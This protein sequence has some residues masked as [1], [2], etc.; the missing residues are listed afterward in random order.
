M[1]WTGKRGESADRG[2]A[3]K[4]S[5]LKDDSTKETTF[6]Q[7]DIAK[8]LAKLDC[9]ES[10]IEQLKRETPKYITAQSSIDKQM[11]AVAKVIRHV[12]SLEVFISLREFNRPI[13]LLHI[14]K[15]SMHYIILYYKW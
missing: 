1:L 15:S 11:S 4:S 10:C 9:Y 12:A 13:S 14:N 7:T 6:Q 2:V 3:A 8:L 5:S